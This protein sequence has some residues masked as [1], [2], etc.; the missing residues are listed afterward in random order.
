MQMSKRS[1]QFET[2]LH[3]REKHHVLGKGTVSFSCSQS[4]VRGR[5]FCQLWIREQTPPP[6]G[7]ARVSL[8]EGRL[9]ERNTEG[10]PTERSGV[11]S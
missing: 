10:F 4:S 5:C 8:G 9:E 6:G 11:A 3:S 7:E 2:L 1:L